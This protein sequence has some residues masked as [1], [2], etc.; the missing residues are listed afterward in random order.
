MYMVYTFA[1]RVILHAFCSQ[2]YTRFGRYNMNPPKITQNETIKVLTKFCYQRTTVSY[3]N[4]QI[5]NTH[6]YSIDIISLARN[7]NVFTKHGKTIV[8]ILVS[9]ESKR[10]SIL[11]VRY[12]F[13]YVQCQ[14]YFLVSLKS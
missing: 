3:E 12:R 1:L 10:F 6:C 7:T 13:I 11:R 14:T 2:L 4:R 5:N 9:F 8:T